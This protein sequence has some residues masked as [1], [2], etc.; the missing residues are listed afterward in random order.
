M[1]AKM[2]G[3]TKAPCNMRMKEFQKLA[4]LFSQQLGINIVTIHIIPRRDLKTIL[5]D[6]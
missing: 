2:G 5:W 3:Q 4:Y 6:V 1:L